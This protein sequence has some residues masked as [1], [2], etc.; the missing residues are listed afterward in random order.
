MAQCS[1]W[2]D[3]VWEMEATLSVTA[4]Q[5]VPP[6]REPTVNE[7]IQKQH[8]ELIKNR[9]IIWYNRFKSSTAINEGWC[10]TSHPSK[11]SLTH[12]FLITADCNLSVRA[13]FSKRYRFPLTRSV[14][15]QWWEMTV[16]NQSTAQS[17]SII[18]IIP[19]LFILVWSIGSARR[20]RRIC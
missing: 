19:S 7:Q 18:A 13:N 11:P 8:L 12:F 1:Q 10:I 4:N 6:Y 14:I 9:V 2:S 16:I 17:A 20:R 5:E 3:C 15:K